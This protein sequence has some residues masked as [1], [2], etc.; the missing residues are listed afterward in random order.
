MKLPVNLLKIDKSLIDDIETN[1]TMRDMVDSVIYMG[2]IM[3]CEVIS[4]GVE[5]ENQLAMLKEHKCDFIQGFVWGKPQ[6]FSDT[7]QLCLQQEA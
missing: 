7:E 2:H 1:Q 5:N 6:S 4:E 3:N